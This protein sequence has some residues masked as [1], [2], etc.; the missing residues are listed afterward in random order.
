M[1]G[2]VQVAEY[3][4]ANWVV[5]MNPYKIGGNKVLRARRIGFSLWP[6]PDVG[7]GAASLALSYKSLTEVP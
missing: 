4:V 3:A 2:L 5:E 6:R 7:H 1:S